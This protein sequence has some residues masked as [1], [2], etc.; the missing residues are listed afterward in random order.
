MSDEWDVRPM[1]KVGD[2][3]RL[4]RCTDEWTSLQ[5]GLLGRVS[6][7]DDAETVFINWDDGHRLGLVA[8][9]GD[10]YEVITEET[11]DGS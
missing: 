4:I 5:P 8:A 9:A 2:R 3:V 7:I 6:F 1:T 11:D 10:H